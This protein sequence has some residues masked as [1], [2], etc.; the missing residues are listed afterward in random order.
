MSKLKKL[1]KELRISNLEDIVSEV[2]FKEPDQYLIDILE[3]AVKHRNNRR[4]KRLIKRAKFP[5]T[6]TLDNY[7]FEPISFPDNLD[8]TDLL[9]LDFIDKKENIM[10]LGSVGTGKTHL[11]TALGIKAC[12]KNKKVKFYRAIDLTNE[13]LEK[14]KNGQANKLI[15]K[16][17]KTDILIL[18]ELGYIPFSKKAAELL[19]S[20]ISNCYEHQSII[21]TSNLEFGR[22]NEVFGDDRLTAALIDR[23]VHHA[24]ILAFTGKSYRFQQAMTNSKKKR[25]EQK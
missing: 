23:V 4:V 16:I 1:C 2:E 25:E 20:V 10:M 17:A 13:L 19:F 22:W 21:V 15:K 6:K 7:D 24:Y 14:Y 12:Q 8:K 9:S 3:L 18:D 5:T 11:A